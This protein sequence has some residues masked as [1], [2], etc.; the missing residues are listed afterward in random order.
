MN[1]G[2]LIVAQFI[3]KGDF[4]LIKDFLEMYDLVVTPK[5][6]VIVRT[7]FYPLDSDFY[8]RNIYYFLKHLSSF[9]DCYLVRSCVRS[10][11]FDYVDCFGL[12]NKLC[13]VIY[14]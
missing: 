12:K 10:F 1:P 2:G 9:P 14:I 4:M 11:G 5:I 8:A 6:P 3:Y 7:A 13:L